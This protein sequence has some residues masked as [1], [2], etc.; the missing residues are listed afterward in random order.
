MPFL[1]K[2]VGDKYKLQKL[3]DGTFVKTEYKSKQSAI[4]AGVNFMNYRHPNDKIYIRGNKILN[5]K[6]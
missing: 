3:K 6:K 4:N 5:K 2:R 1:V